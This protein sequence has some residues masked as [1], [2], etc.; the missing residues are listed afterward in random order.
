MEEQK[1]RRIV[2]AVAATATL[3]LIIL[4]FVMIYQMILIGN[5]QKKIEDL[6][7]EIVSLQEEKKD[8]ENRIEIWQT[9]WKIDERARELG[10]LY[11]Y[12]K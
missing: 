2:A 9:D 7:A 1:L 8:M 6:N 11:G 5:G 10:W 12:T 4:L 3:L